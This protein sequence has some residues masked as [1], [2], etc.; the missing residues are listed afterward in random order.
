MNAPSFILRPPKADDIPVYTGFLAQP[1]VSVWLDDSAQ[2]PMTAAQVETILFRDAW[3]LWAIECDGQLVGVTSLYEPNL[4]QNT[5]RLSIV[6]GDRRY[7]G[8]G[9]GTAAVNQVIRHGFLALGLRKI[10]SDYL[11][12]ND[13]VRIVHERA[14]FAEEGILREDAWRNGGWVDR[15]FLSYLRSDYL[16]RHPVGSG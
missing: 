8:K 13:G 1:E 10:N 2:F 14:G 5:A 7:W 12:P 11:R 4:A 3:C 9:L 15:V 16:T 6:I